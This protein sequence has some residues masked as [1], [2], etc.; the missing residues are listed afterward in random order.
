M[1]T[2]KLKSKPVNGRTQ[3]ADFMKNLKHPLKKEIEEVRKIILTSDKN[4]TEEIKWNAPSFG[5]K[6]DDR[7]TFNLH[8]KDFFRLIFHCGAKVKNNKS[9]E[10]LFEDTTGLLDWAANDRAIA[11]FTDMK[12]VK[13]KKEALVTTIHT[14]LKVTSE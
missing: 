4:L 3:V 1:K 9:K 2:D 11:K 8:G 10:R 12:D 13:S 7:I 6:G 14:W 5:Y